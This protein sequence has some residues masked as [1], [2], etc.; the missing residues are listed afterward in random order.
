M[1]KDRLTGKPLTRLQSIRWRLPLTYAAIVLLTVAIISTTLL[2][3]LNH[4]YTNRELSYLE[5]NARSVAHRVEDML[6]DELPQEVLDLAMVPLSFFTRARVRLLDAEGSA[7]ADSASQDVARG[8][9]LSLAPPWPIQISGEV[10]P[11][12]TQAN[13]DATPPVAAGT[14]FSIQLEAPDR[15]GDQAARAERG[16]YRLWAADAP[17]GYQLSGENK[18]DITERSD[19]QVTVALND[20]SGALIGYLEFSEGPAFGTEVINSVTDALL[21]AM[22]LAIPLSIVIGWGISRS[23]SS[24]VLTLTRATRQ[25]ADG[26]LAVRVKLDRQD[27]LGTLAQT[28]NTM[29]GQIE[30]TV[31]TLKRFVG[32]AAHE[33]KTPI[34]AMR[35]NLELAAEGAL[36]DNALTDLSRAQHELDR[37]ERLTSSLL[38]LARL[39][40]DTRET[41]LE[42]LALGE[43]VRQFHERYASRAEQAGITLDCTTP[44]E[45]VTISG[46]REQIIQLLDNLLENAVKF[47]L[48]GGTVTLTL[49]APEDETAR[50]HVRDSG[51]GIPKEDLPRLFSRFHRGSNAAAYP[52]NGLGLVIART[53]VEDHGGSIDVESSPAGTCFTVTLPLA[54]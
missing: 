35:T 16:D 1:K 53:I 33:I 52:G 19:Q 30:D 37:L 24:P 54:E 50:L 22:L 43:L 7:I 11:L 40:A 48:E 45:E 9:M 36:D 27:E 28:F 13:T 23:I 47:T 38:A 46:N 2:V 39:E 26:N 14:S 51:I 3:A 44:P 42:T 17:F 10:V 6:A 41:T 12:S 15:R 32:D 29:A 18:S 4:Y 8:F 20:R 5:G 25:M 31:S 34:T 49:D 21:I